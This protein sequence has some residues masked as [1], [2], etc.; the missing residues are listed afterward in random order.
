MVIILEF[1]LKIENKDQHLVAFGK[2]NPL[3]K[4]PACLESFIFLSGKSCWVFLYSAF[5]LSLFSGDDVWSG[6]IPEGWEIQWENDDEW[7]AMDGLPC[8]SYD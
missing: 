4:K 3:A 7:Y 6:P 8:V 5:W 2:T 1:E